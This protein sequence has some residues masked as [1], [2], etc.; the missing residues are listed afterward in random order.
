[1]RWTEQ[2]CERDGKR[3]SWFLQKSEGEKEKKLVLQMHPLHITQPLRMVFD[4][5]KSIPYRIR[6][7]VLLG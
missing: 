5:V 6:E 7:W 3:R 2:L 4:G 1:M